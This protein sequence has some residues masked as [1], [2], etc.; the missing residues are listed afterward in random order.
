MLGAVVCSFIAQPISASQASVSSEV[1][2]ASGL[3]N[4]IEDEWVAFYE[5]DVS[6]TQSSNAQE[7]YAIKRNQLGV[8]YQVACGMV[9]INPKNP[10][11]NHC[12][13]STV[14][15]KGDHSKNRNVRHRTSLTRYGIKCVSWE[16]S[17]DQH[18][19]YS[20]T[21][22]VI[23]EWDKL[24]QLRAIVPGS[25]EERIARAHCRNPQ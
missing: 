10:P 5:A 11:K 9:A 1:G 17:K 13:T 16:Y 8:G 14:W 7:V 24:G 15:I 25:F 23:Q 4:D 22:V 12:G 6:A 21:G 3:R 19:S 2:D 18:I 20:A